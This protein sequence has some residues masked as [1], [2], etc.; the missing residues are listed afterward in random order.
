MYYD[1]SARANSQSSNKRSIHTARG[2]VPHRRSRARARLQLTCKKRLY[3]P[4]NSSQQEFTNKM[5][6]ELNQQ[7][8][9]MQ[10]GVSNLLNQLHQRE[11]AGHSMQ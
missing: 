6:H 1:S 2:E 11:D 10:L 3:K 5:A 7:V 8:N 9:A 4:I